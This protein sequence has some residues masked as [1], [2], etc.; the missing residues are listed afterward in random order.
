MDSSSSSLPSIA[1]VERALGPD[2]YARA[3]ALAD[4]HAPTAEQIR[5][6]RNVFGTDR[7]EA[8]PVRERRPG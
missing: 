7:P 8:R 5:I 1:D 4:D 2:L 6:L 3:C